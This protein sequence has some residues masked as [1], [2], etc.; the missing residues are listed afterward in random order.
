MHIKPTKIVK[1]QGFFRLL[2]GA[3]NIQEPE[4]T[5]DFEA[6]NQISITDPK[7]QYAALVFY[8]KNGYASS[9][10][11]YKNKRAIK[12]KAKNFII[13]NDVLFKRN[14]DSILLICL[15]KPE[16]RKVLQELHDE[17]A[18]RHF[19]ADTT[20]HKIIHVGYY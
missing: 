8:L 11:S 3:S 12:L 4:G 2:A 20:A 10:L 7:S 18:G 1:G 5:K 16:A 13:V 14:Y 9:N 15:E 17:P 19:G 6:I